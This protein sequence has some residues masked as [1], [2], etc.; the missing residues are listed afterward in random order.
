MRRNG[1]DVELSAGDP[2]DAGSTGL[3]ASIWLPL[4]PMRAVAVRRLTLPTDLS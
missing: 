4:A 3:R 1:G 2:N